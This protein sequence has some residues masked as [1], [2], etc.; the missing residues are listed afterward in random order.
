MRVNGCIFWDHSCG[1][2]TAHSWHWDVIHLLLG[3]SIHL[4]NFRDDTPML[5]GAKKSKHSH[6][7]RSPFHSQFRTSSLNSLISIFSVVYQNRDSFHSQSSLQLSFPTASDSSTKSRHQNEVP[8]GKLLHNYGK[9]PFFMGKST[10]SMAIFNSSFDITRGYLG[11][12]PGLHTI[13]LHGPAP[14][15]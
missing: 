11:T 5:Q 2:I 13:P 8:S 9:S 14:A 4:A 15:C 10:I 3:L 12:S 6:V 7:R 1:K